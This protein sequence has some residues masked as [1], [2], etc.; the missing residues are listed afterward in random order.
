M[1]VA[2]W[3]DF[4]VD[5]DVHHTWSNDA[6]LLPYLDAR[7]RSYFEAV[8]SVLPAGALYS[9]AGGSAMRLDSAPPGG[10]APGSH[11]PTMC[12]QHLDAYGIDRAVLTFGFGTQGAYFHPAAGV[13]LC[14]AA[15]DWTLD[16]WLTGVDDRLYGLIMMAPGDPIAAAAEIRRV[17]SHPR[18]VG[19]L[20]VPSPHMHPLGH[21]VHDPIYE[22]A[23]E[24]GL[25][26]VTHVGSE[27][28]NT[29]TLAAGGLPASKPEYYTLLEQP[30]MH[31]FTSLLAGGTFARFPKLRVLFS[32]QGFCWAPS[33]LWGL[34]ARYA[35]L[36]R[37][38]PELDRLPSEYFREHIWMATQPFETGAKRRALFGLLETLGGIEERLCFASDYPH[39]DTDPPPQVAGRLP[40]AWR[41]RVMG[42]NAAELFGLPIPDRTLQHAGADQELSQ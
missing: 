15:N 42:L 12:A 40:G 14:R 11:Y 37:E 8:G 13:A 4:L 30:G 31:H 17:G 21:P 41:E 28:S 26:I 36:R 18:L 22:A 9:R 39:W 23:S 20:I 3:G 10:G 7:W 16:R 27:F 19:A 34:D 6:E 38:H 24:L 33:V 25:P 29:G 1:A 35:A 32:E 5:V 2:A